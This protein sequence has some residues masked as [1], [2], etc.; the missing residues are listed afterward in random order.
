[1]EY[2]AAGL[3]VLASDILANRDVLGSDYATAFFENTADSLAKALLEIINNEPLRKEMGRANRN[4]ILRF[5]RFDPASLW[6]FSNQAIQ[7]FD[8]KE[9]SERT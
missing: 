3:P 6:P 2:M 1:M 5:H 8:L 7:T 4:R 9:N